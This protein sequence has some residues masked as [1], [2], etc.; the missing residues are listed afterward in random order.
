MI[1]VNYAAYRLNVA[2][3]TISVDCE[4]NQCEI[5]DGQ[6]QHD[7]S[8]IGL[9]LKLVFELAVL[10]ITDILTESIQDHVVSQ[11]ETGHTRNGPA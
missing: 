1:A 9:G 4:E 5:S 3:C 2:H 6:R 7:A 11:V 8:S 10:C